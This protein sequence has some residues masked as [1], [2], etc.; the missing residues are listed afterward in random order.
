MMAYRNIDIQHILPENKVHWKMAFCPK[1]RE[2][3][4]E[5]RI[6]IELKDKKRQY[7]CLSFEQ[8]FELITKIPLEK[9]CFYE[10]ISCGDAVKFY[11]DYEYYK[12]HQ[13][14]II[15]VKKALFCIRKLFI[16]VIKVMSY[17][18][19]ISICDMLVLESSSDQ[20]ESYHIILDNKDIRF[21]D[22]ISVNLFVKE[23][24]RIILLATI[25][26]DCLRNKKQ[27]DN[28]LNNESSLLDVI[29]VFNLVWLEWFACVNCKI[30][31]TDLSVNDISNL[32]VHN[33]KGHM[34]PCIDLK[35]SAIE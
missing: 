12:N 1:R 16:D 24:L 27:I 11:L 18:Q 34:V 6:S 35:V 7:T 10:H 28:S 8:L 2:T 21:A 5:Y 31:N 33:Q 13:N 15:D 29:D 4:N 30:K 20:K 17:N 3:H 23:V 14:A 25:E 22:N 19:T 32:F 9:R 26:Q